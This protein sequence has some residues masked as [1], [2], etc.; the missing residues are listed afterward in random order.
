[1]RLLMLLMSWLLHFLHR[2][3]KMLRYA[4]TPVL[5]V[6]Q[7]VRFVVCKEIG[8][9]LLELMCAGEYFK[10]RCDET[11]AAVVAVNLVEEEEEEDRKSVV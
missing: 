3:K 9:A 7:R 1:M 10:V 4:M 11:A 5:H 2:P 8:V 6:W